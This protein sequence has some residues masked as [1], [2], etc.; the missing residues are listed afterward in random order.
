M[1]VCVC[2]CKW[3]RGGSHAANGC[4]CACRGDSVAISCL[5]VAV[6]FLPPLS[7][8]M[9]FPSQLAAARLHQR[10]GCGEEGEAGE[11]AAALS[12]ELLPSQPRLLPPLRRCCRPGSAHIWPTCRRR[13]VPRFMLDAE[14]TRGGCY[15]DVRR[16]FKR[17]S[18]CA[19]SWMT[20]LAR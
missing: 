6:F 17:P 16:A 4:R 11:E 13:R 14:A 20:A 19:A 1:C 10:E 7:R 2:A 9:R 15:C 12:N 8:V 18:P 3:G 5:V